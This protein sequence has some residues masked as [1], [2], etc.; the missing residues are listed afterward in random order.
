[1]NRYVVIAP[2]QAPSAIAGLLV[3]QDMRPLHEPTELNV[4]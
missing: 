2:E 4:I 1:M 3:G